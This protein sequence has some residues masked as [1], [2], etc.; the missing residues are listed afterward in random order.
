MNTFITKTSAHNLFKTINYFIIQDSKR[1]R[2]WQV[3][4]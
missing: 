1:L 3:P 2:T 4:Q